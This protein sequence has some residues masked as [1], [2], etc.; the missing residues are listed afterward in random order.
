MTWINLGDPAPKNK[1]SRHDPYEWKTGEVRVL[2][3]PYQKNLEQSNFFTIL[4]ERRSS[5]EFG[6]LNM[7]LLSAFLWHS[8][9][10][11]E[12]IPSGMGF[13]LERRPAPSAG[14]I[15]PIH[16]LLQQ[17]ADPRWWLYNPKTHALI[18][19]VEADSCL[20]GL[21]DHSRNVLPSEAATQILL[22]AEPGKTAA[23]YENSCSL[24]WRDAGALIGIMALTA[25]ALRLNFCPLG[26]TGEP[27]VFNLGQQGQLAG[28]GMALLGSIPAPA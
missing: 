27:W 25:Q 16:V 22:V 18:E 15:H 9:L 2:A 5:R 10:S 8:S 7:D 24:V 6:P 17:N 3:E 4:R 11:R 1:F 26:I 13:D 23:K 12:A 14:A 21:S 19:A 20:Q 28:V